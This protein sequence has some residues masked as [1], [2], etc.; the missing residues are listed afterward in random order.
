MALSGKGVLDE[1]R[2]VEIQGLVSQFFFAGGLSTIVG[3]AMAWSWALMYAWAG[4]VTALD[5]CR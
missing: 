4:S 1:L 5:R 3:Q 2:G